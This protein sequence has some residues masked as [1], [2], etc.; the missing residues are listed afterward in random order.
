MTEIAAV[1]FNQTKFPSFSRQLSNWGFKR[2][3]QSGPDSGCYYHEKFLRGLPRLTVLMQ[4]VQPSQGKPAPSE[5]GEPDF[6]RISSLYPLPEPPISSSSSQKDHLAP[7]EERR[8]KET[9]VAVAALHPVMDKYTSGYDL[10]KKQHSRT[11]TAQRTNFPSTYSAT[12]STEPPVS[13]K[14]PQIHVDGVTSGGNNMSPVQDSSMSSIANADNLASLIPMHCVPPV[15]TDQDS[16]INRTQ[17][18]LKSPSNVRAVASSRQTNYPSFSQTPNASNAQQQRNY[19]LLENPSYTNEQDQ[20]MHSAQEPPANSSAGAVATSQQTNYLS[21]DQMPDNLKIL[22]TYGLLPDPTMASHPMSRSFASSSVGSA[23]VQNPRTFA[24]NPVAPAMF[25]PAMVASISSNRGSYLTSAAA[26]NTDPQR[27][28]VAA[29][30][31]YSMHGQPPL[32]VHQ[33]E[34]AAG[35]LGQGEHAAAPQEAY[36]GEAAFE[37]DMKKF[38][39]NFQP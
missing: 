19:G 38:F 24:Q 7:T 12:A 13:T 16:S 15:K 1:Y 28:H 23:N 37:D 22:R 34:T 36:E 4:T 17:E 20:S 31:H 30:N 26:S 2:L 6:Y 18:Y 29:H 10:S 8:A 33:Q 9:V 32:S 27:Y 14:I 11:V 39:D 25:A 35:K 3:R 21:L 5:Q